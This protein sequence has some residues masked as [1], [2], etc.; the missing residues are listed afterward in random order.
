MNENHNGVP[1]IN[2][3]ANNGGATTPSLSGV[4]GHNSDVSNIAN[5]EARKGASPSGLRSDD[6]K[7]SLSRSSSGLESKSFNS[8]NNQEERRK[9]MNSSKMQNLK[10]RA[11]Q[12]LIKKYAQSKGVPAGIVDKAMKSSAGEKVMNTLLGGKKKNPLM[13]KLGGSNTDSKKKDES[14][15]SAEE[16][17]QE[18]EDRRARDGVMTFQMTMKTLK[19]IILVAPAVSLILFFVLV[20]VVS[21]NDDKAASMILGEMSSSDDGR[22]AVSEGIKSDSGNGLGLGDELAVG[23]GLEKYPPYYYD[24]LASLGN[25][26]N[27]DPECE[28]DNCMSTSEVKY[29]LKVA[30]IA[31]R[32]RNKYN[33]SL[34]WRLITAANLYMSKETEET[35]KA[36]LNE[37]N[38]ES[39]TNYSSLMDLDW[40]YDYKKISGYYYLDADNSKY[41]LQILAKN[42]VKKK[43]TQQC[44]D[45]SGNVV[46]SEEVE[47]VEDRYLEA[48]GEKSLSCGAGESYTFSSTYTKDLDKF[49]EFLLEYIDNKMFLPGSGTMGD[50]CSDGSIKSSENFVWPVGSMETTKE[51][52]VEFALGNPAS[53]KVTSGFGNK[54]EF[55]TSA[56][57][58]MDIS[59]NGKIGEIPVIAVQDGTVVEAVDGFNSV[60]YYGCKDGGGWGNH[61]IIRHNDK[62]TT[63]YAHMAKGTLVVKKGDTVKQ[64]QVLGKIGSSGS[65][66]GPHLHIEVWEGTSSS[67]RTAPSE[68]LDANNPR[69]D[70]TSTA[71]GNCTTSTGMSSAFVQLAVEQLQDPSAKGGQKY[72]SYMGFGGRVAWCAC[73]VSWTVWHTSYNGQNLSDII[74]FKH[75]CVYAWMNYFYAKSEPYLDFKYNDN[76]SRY[77]GKNGGG[78]YTPKEGDMIFFDWAA[79]WNG[80]MPT[81]FDCG[82]D[83]IG[84]VQRVENGNIITIEGNASDSVKERTIALN[85]CQVIG[86]GSWY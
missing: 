21:F 72:W 38:E 30:D 2:Q 51:G 16:K 23:K 58:G 75:A 26:F 68:Y 73:F 43:T 46:K 65:S 13:D 35:M 50:N 47:D 24:R 37:Y 8:L 9:R 19:W 12:E 60:G 29:Y 82:P 48:G 69:P 6:Y 25:N 61:V 10:Q 41:D 59:G 18:E 67:A 31:L 70:G 22:K 14:E 42:M 79:S 33:V 62:L 39:V 32:Y 45:A 80:H 57:G 1:K 5:A 27:P 71:L 54:E 78:T 44:I 81:C 85:S 86:F 40:D 83:H 3:H 15:K 76:C 28:G 77:A 55:R 4:N 52:G 11:A 36:N 63:V 7:K 34:D 20:V 74:K 64:G 49:N 56:H 84:I 53:T 17:G 66:T